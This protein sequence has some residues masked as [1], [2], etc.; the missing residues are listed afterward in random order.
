MLFSPFVV[1]ES[2]KADVS[3]VTAQKTHSLLR[4][5]LIQI[6]NIRHSVTVWRR[7]PPVLHPAKCQKGTHFEA[8]LSAGNPVQFSLTTDQ[9][10]THSDFS[11]HARLCFSIHAVASESSELMLLTANSDLS[12]CRSFSSS[13][14]ALSP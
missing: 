7:L 5:R 1:D 4:V 12:K 6:E 8:S 14:V 3:I 2:F 13:V 10:F 11:Q 9:S